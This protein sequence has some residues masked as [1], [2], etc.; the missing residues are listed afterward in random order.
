M[1]FTVIESKIG[2]DFSKK[3]K[4]APYYDQ[5]TRTVACISAELMGENISPDSLHNFGFLAIAPEIMIPK[6]N[7]PH[8]MTKD[9]MKRIVD[10]RISDLNDTNQEKLMVWYNDC[11][12][13]DIIGWITSSDFHSILLSKSQLG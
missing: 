6:G 9:H 13:W 1:D 2:T 3:V 5:A 4:N 7:I 8:F 11:F 10:Q 12:T